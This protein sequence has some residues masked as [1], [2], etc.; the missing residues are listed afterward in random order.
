MNEAAKACGGKGGERR[1][2]HARGAFR[3]VG[4]S[5]GGSRAGATHTTTLPDPKGGLEEEAGASLQ[6]EPLGAGGTQDD[7]AHRGCAAGPR[8]ALFSAGR[9][10]SVSGRAVRETA[11]VVEAMT[12]ISAEPLGMRAGPLR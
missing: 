2:E 12:F 10:R 1:N 4:T 5:F 6:A 9:A 7:E 8:V 3:S 11:Q